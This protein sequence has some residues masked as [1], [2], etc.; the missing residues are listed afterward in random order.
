M[1]PFKDISAE[2]GLSL[3]TRSRALNGVLQLKAPT[4]KRVASALAGYCN[5]FAEEWCP[6]P[7]SF[8][9]T[10]LPLQRD[11]DTLALDVAPC[12][13]GL[14][15][16]AI[17]CGSILITAGMLQAASDLWLSVPVN[18]SDSANGGALPNLFAIAF[19]RSLTVTR[20]PLCDTGKPLADA[21]IDRSDDVHASDL[22]TLVRADLVMCN[23][24]A[25]VPWEGVS[26]WPLT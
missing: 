21:L 11:G 26:S 12:R 23:S 14:R 10:A 22:Q 24:A 16:T 7:R 5:A 8:I 4:P 2:P 19:D 15:P 20:A 13:A 6:V 17:A 3:A 9:S 18:L 1:T 25:H